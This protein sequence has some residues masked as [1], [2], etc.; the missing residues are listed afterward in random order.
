[1]GLSRD[2]FLAYPVVKPSVQVQFVFDEAMRDIDARASN[3]VAES[4]TLAALRATL[5]P[6]LISGELR[7]KE[8][9]HLCATEEA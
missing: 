8:T 9:H 5:L 1:L 6:K 3:A 7:V 4:R 2:D